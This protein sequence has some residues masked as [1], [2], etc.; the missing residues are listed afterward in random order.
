MLGLGR[1]HDRHRLADEVASSP[2]NMRRAE[3]FIHS[4]PRLPTVTMPTSTESRI[5][6]VRS[7]I[8]SRSSASASSW[9][10]CDL[11]RVTSERT[12]IASSKPVAPPARRTESEYQRRPGRA[13]PLPSSR[14]PLD[15]AAST[16]SKANS[17]S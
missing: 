13:T 16:P 2:A 4:M 6:R 8:S 15:E 5:E 10:C 14:S 3:R 12:A 7:A 17:V 9:S 11:S 1:R